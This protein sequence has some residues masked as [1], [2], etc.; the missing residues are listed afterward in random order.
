MQGAWS[1]GQILVAMLLVGIP[2]AAVAGWARRLVID[3]QSARRLRRADA[4]REARRRPAP[5]TSVV[6]GW[7]VEPGGAGALQ[8]VTQRQFG[9][10]GG[11]LMHVV[12]PFELELD[13]G[14]RTR[15]E[16][17]DDP[18]VER[19]ELLA[20]SVAPG[21]DA[22]PELPPSTGAPHAVHV[23]RGRVRVAGV[24]AVGSGRFVPPPD[25]SAVMTIV[26]P[27]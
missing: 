1:V 25:A 12:P 9:C 19:L 4:E 26:A 24:L 13:D 20:S 2:M 14:T 16:V 21:S 10:L 22:R 15:V 18:V 3:A 5:G 8:L 17:G 6:E 27:A 23:L 11:P 7:V